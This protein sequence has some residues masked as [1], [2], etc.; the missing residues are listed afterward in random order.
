[1]LWWTLV[2]QKVLAKKC[3][4]SGGSDTYLSTWKTEIS[5]IT[6]PI[7]WFCWMCWIREAVYFLFFPSI[8]DF[9]LS[10]SKQHMFNFEYKAGPSFLNVFI[11]KLCHVSLVARHVF[12]STVNAEQCL[13]SISLGSLWNV[14][15]SFCYLFSFHKEKCS[16]IF[17]TFVSHLNANVWSSN[18]CC[19]CVCCDDWQ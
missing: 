16:F 12:L 5:Q 9:W 2:F 7:L 15:S 13:L 4:D 18:E 17:L 1:M 19:A 8:F 14:E 3:S 6:E 11:Q 10:E